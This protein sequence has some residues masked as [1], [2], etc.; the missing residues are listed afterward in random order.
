MSKL[1]LLSVLFGILTWPDVPWELIRWAGISLMVVVP[2]LFYPLSLCI[3]LASD[4]LIRPV[5]DEELEWSRTNPSTLFRK[6]RE[7]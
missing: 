7:R 2:F 5:T 3:W 1:L 6:Y 4:I